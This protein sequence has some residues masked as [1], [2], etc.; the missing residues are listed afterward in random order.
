M[1]AAKRKRTKPAPAGQP[2]RRSKKD[3]VRDITEL[4]ASGQW[5][6]GVTGP[7]LAA[8]WGM[9]L[10]TIERD[11]AEASRRVR[12]AV[13]EDEGLRSRILLTLET[14]TQRAIK[15]NQLRT[16]VEAAKALA[17]VSGVEAPKKVELGGSLAD[18]LSLG[19]GDGSEETPGEV[20]T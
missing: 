2:A 8:K 1:A 13:E 10:D 19:M 15:K 9:S 5:V 11:S 12:T 18:F 14:I 4:M 16:A 20:G 7:Q 3:R 17:G 6:T